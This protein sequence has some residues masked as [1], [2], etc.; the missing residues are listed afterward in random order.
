[1]ATVFER[2]KQCV[3]VQLNIDPDE[4]TLKGDFKTDLRADSLDLVELIM[5]LEEEFE[6]D[7]GKLEISDEDAQKL[8][9]VE[10]VVAYLMDHGVVDSAKAEAVTAA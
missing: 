2:V 10:E 3:V 1:M 8:T 5:K 7:I 9:T 6:G 4:V